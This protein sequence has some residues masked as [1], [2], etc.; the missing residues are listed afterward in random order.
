MVEEAAVTHSVANR[1]KDVFSCIGGRWMGED[2]WH[3][4]PLLDHPCPIGSGGDRGLAG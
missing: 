4:N 3:A 1:T 2:N